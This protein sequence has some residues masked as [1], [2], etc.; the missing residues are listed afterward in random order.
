MKHDTYDMKSIFMWTGSTL[1]NIFGTITRTDV[2]FYLGVISTSVVII[3][4]IIK[5]RKE[6]PNK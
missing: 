3:Y 5:I 1:L 2:T 6:L 4:H